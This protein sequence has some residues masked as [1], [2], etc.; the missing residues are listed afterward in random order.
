V[1]LGGDI[2]SLGGAALMVQISE[3]MMHDVILG[4]LGLSVLAAIVA[5]GVTWT[6]SQFFEVIE[7]D[8]E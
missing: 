6:Y 2:H 5:M 4:L 3:Y 7:R 8:D 1:Q